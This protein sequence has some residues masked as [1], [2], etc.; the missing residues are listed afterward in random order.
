MRRVIL[1]GLIGALGLGFFSA[2]DGILI[3]LL[4][5]YFTQAEN[6]APVVLTWLFWFG[7]VGGA[8]G[9][10]IGVVFACTQ[11]RLMLPPPQERESA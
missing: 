6:L 8:V 5:A 10:A 7:L 9:A 2:I 4:V 3:G 1:A 11:H